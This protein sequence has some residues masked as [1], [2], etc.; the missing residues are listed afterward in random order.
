[1]HTHECLRAYLSSYTY[2]VTYIECQ[3]EFAYL[4]RYL[5]S[6]LMCLLN[7]IALCLIISTSK[8]LKRYHLPSRDSTS[9]W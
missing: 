2:T 1:M 4:G 9:D 7:L 6:S 8:K 5:S 3:V